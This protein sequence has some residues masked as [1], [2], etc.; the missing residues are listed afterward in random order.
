MRYEVIDPFYGKGIPEKTF[1][2]REEAVRY[3]A[4]L[5]D[6]VYLEIKEVPT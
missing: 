5:L 6:V 3:V 1:D 4:T 2:T